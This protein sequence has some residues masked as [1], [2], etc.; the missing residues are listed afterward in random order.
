MP[1]RPLSPGKQKPLLAT[2]VRAKTRFAKRRA[3][4]TS[5]TL[6]AV[7]T[8]RPERG[9]PVTNYDLSPVKTPKPLR[10]H[11]GENYDEKKVRNIYKFKRYE[12]ASLSYAGINK[13]GE[14]DIGLYDTVISSKE[15]GAAFVN[16]P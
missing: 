4:K 12:D 14:K 5:G 16:K 13:H 10:R 2:G 3:G 11:F 7:A 1:V 9:Y 8:L 15:F 6:R